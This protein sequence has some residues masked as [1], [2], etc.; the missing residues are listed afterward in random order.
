MIINLQLL[1][2]QL[3]NIHGSN[4]RGYATPSGIFG[5][6]CILMYC[7][8][9][10]WASLLLWIHQS[11][12]HR[13]I[14]IKEAK[15]G[16]QQMAIIGKSYCN[17]LARMIKSPNVLTAGC[18]LLQWWYRMQRVGVGFYACVCDRWQGDEQWRVNDT[19]TDGDGVIN[20]HTWEI[21]KSHMYMWNMVACKRLSSKVGGWGVGGI[22]SKKCSS[23]KLSVWRR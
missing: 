16:Y 9:L 23:K 10:V 7:D 20:G 15:C 17:S 22:T 21:L 2:T 3:S 12:F 19:L 13:K 14:M 5:S 4:I 6:P 1:D 18:C 11:G 8:V